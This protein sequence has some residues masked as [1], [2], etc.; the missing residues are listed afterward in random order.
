MKGKRLT[1]YLIIWP[2]LTVAYTATVLLYF[3]VPLNPGLIDSL[4]YNI[5]LFVLGFSMW[6]AIPYMEK[7]IKNLPEL[8][9][10]HIALASMVIASSVFLTS[11]LEGFVLDPS[12]QL[13]EELLQAKIFTG[14]LMF[15]FIVMI[16]YFTGYR[17]KIE[18][19]KVKEEELT[20]L[21]NE[22]ELNLLKSQ[23]NPHFIFNS[24]NSISSLTITNPDKARNMVVKLSD[25][26]RYSLSKGKDEQVALEEELN[27]VS[28][29]LEI[30]KTRFGDRLNL[31]LNVEESAKSV[32]V[33]ILILQPL[34]ENA[35]KYSVY[36]SVDGA[37]INLS[38]HI[39]NQQLL[40]EISNP[41]DPKDVSSQGKGIGINNVKQRLQ[42]IFGNKADIRIKK[43]TGQ[44][45]C[46][47]TLPIY[48]QNN[49][50][51][52]S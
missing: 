48:K 19:R 22:A 4:V 38:A 32:L 2:V 50:N 49:S 1:Y 25:F 35:V 34:I 37:T 18:E 11:K 12:N 23:L 14:A 47:V 21:L 8:S 42:I 3:K 5:V 51:I 45:T 20:G 29:F 17:D 6:F 26:L 28:I 7:G 15:V 43:S 13:P 10:A 24:L 44:F 30:E 36:D 40:I 39:K 9:I 33:P 41:Y 52:S 31:N 16:Y 46:T 27:N